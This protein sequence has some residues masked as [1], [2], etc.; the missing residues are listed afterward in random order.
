MRGFLIMLDFLTPRGYF[1]YQRPTEDNNNPNVTY[2]DERGN[3]IESTFRY[4]GPLKGRGQGEPGFFLQ[5][6]DPDNAVVGKTLAKFDL[7]AAIQEAVLNALLPDAENPLPEELRSSVNCAKLTALHNGKERDAGGKFIGLA[8]IQKAVD[9]QDMAKFMVSPE[10]RAPQA[11]LREVDKAYASSLDN[12]RDALSEEAQFH[13]AAALLQSE[14]ANDESKHIGQF[15]LLLDARGQIEKVVRIDLGAAYR[16]AWAKQLHHADSPLKASIFYNHH[17]VVKGEAL[18]LET[19]F[20]SDPLGKDYTSSQLR[21][22]GIRAK[23]L[24]LALERPALTEATII[25]RFTGLFEQIPGDAVQQ[26]R[27]AL[28]GFAAEFYKDAYDPNQAKAEDEDGFELLDDFKFNEH[29]KKLPKAY[30]AWKKIHKDLMD[31]QEAREKA[32]ADITQAGANQE[33]EQQARNEFNTAENMIQDLT[34]AKNDALIACENILRKICLPDSES[35]GP[36]VDDELNHHQEGSIAHGLAQ[37]VAEATL[38]KHQAIVNH[39]QL[40]ITRCVNGANVGP[41]ISN[42]LTT[43]ASTAPLTPEQIDSLTAKHTQLTARKKSPLVRKLIENRLTLNRCY[44]EDNTLKA[45]STAVIT[46]LGLQGEKRRELLKTAKQALKSIAHLTP[47]A[48]TALKNINNALRQRPGSEPHLYDLLSK[49][50]MFDIL[51]Q[52][53]LMAEAPQRKEEVKDKR[54]I[55]WQKEAPTYSAAQTLFQAYYKSFDL[56]GRNALAEMQDEEIEVRQ[57]F[58][59]SSYTSL[60]MSHYARQLPQRVPAVTAT[61]REILAIFFPDDK[62]MDDDAKNQHISTN[63]LDKLPL[64]HLHWVASRAGA[65]WCMEH[66]TKSALFNQQVKRLDFIKVHKGCHQLYAAIKKLPPHLRAYPDTELRRIID[67]LRNGA[68]NSKQLEAQLA[69]LIHAT[70]KAPAA[71][72]TQW[73][74][75]L[76]EGLEQTPRI[77]QAIEHIR[78]EDNATPLHALLKKTLITHVMDEYPEHGQTLWE[79]QQQSLTLARVTTDDERVQE[80]ATLG[81][82]YP[83]FR[84]LQEAD[85]SLIAQY[86]RLLQDENPPTVTQGARAIL[87]SLTREAALTTSPEQ[88]YFIASRAGGSNWYNNLPA[89]DNADEQARILTLKGLFVQG[90]LLASHENLSLLINKLRALPTI[91]D[92][93]A[94]HIDKLSTSLGLLLSLPNNADTEQSIQNLIRQVDKYRAFLD[95]AEKNPLSSADIEEMMQAF[96]LDEGEMTS[97]HALTPLQDKSLHPFLPNVDAQTDGSPAKQL[98]GIALI[99]HIHDLARAKTTPQAL[100]RQAKQLLQQVPAAFSDRA[101]PIIAQL[102]AEARRPDDHAKHPQAIIPASLIFD[103]QQE[104]QAEKTHDIA[105]GLEALS[106]YGREAGYLDEGDEQVDEEALAAAEEQR[107]IRKAE[108]R[109]LIDERREQSPDEKLL[110]LYERELDNDEHE[111][112]AECAQ[113]ALR[114]FLRDMAANRPASLQQFSVADFHFV[115]SRAGSRWIN[116]NRDTYP[117]LDTFLKRVIV[118][119]RPRTTREALPLL[120]HTPALHELFVTIK[121]LP[122]GAVRRHANALLNALADDSLVGEEERLQAEHVAQGLASFLKAYQKNPHFGMQELLSFKALFQLQPNAAI[123]PSEPEQKRLTGLPASPHDLFQREGLTPTQRLAKIFMNVLYQKERGV[124]I[125][126]RVAIEALNHDNSQFGQFARGFIATPAPQ[127]ARDIDNEKYPTYSRA[128]Q[129]ID[130]QREDD[131]NRT[132]FIRQEETLVGRLSTHKEQQLALLRN[133]FL[134]LDLAV[135]EMTLANASTG[136]VLQ[137]FDAITNRVGDTLQRQ[138]KQEIARCV[139]GLG[140]DNNGRHPTAGFPPKGLLIEGCEE[141]YLKPTVDAFNAKCA[142]SRQ[143]LE[144]KVNIMRQAKVQNKLTGTS[145]PRAAEESGA[146]ANFSLTGRAAQ[147]RQQLLTATTISVNKA[148]ITIHP[149]GR[150]TGLDQFSDTELL[151]WLRGKTRVFG[152]KVKQNFAE[153]LA[154]AGYRTFNL[155]MIRHADLK[156]Q[157]ACHHAAEEGLR[158]Y[159][160]GRPVSERV[161]LLQNQEAGN[162]P[163]PNFDRDNNEPVD[164]HP[165]PR[166]TLVH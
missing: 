15:M 24:S 162:A 55:P 70:E 111:D 33:A 114:A 86:Y 68:E 41:A 60:L 148:F 112:V 49:R 78:A 76:L 122:P 10:G 27:E 53:T 136:N 101:K 88:A 157:A 57:A 96:D 46:D 89:G 39:A 34:G 141:R 156:M 38:S 144:T 87:T 131:A 6:L 51:D 9:G 66:R 63:E 120:G 19:V 77:A 163:L 128:K 132:T 102:D 1:T 37:H 103:M 142:E 158:R 85:Q 152:F 92:T 145:V 45:A 79:L 7:E 116:D 166:P 121:G 42:L 126:P 123:F 80:L 105:A 124:P 54:K 107:D 5:Q 8:S 2:R 59:E 164:N 75:N 32:I 16:Y 3:E 23:F 139:S 138:C 12:A 14:F 58:V 35:T 153:V 50:V 21:H 137:R 47:E 4:V 20:G 64:E 31:A 84:D 127:R 100:C 135:E 119:M 118:I 22:P 117:L 18:G 71:A 48:K 146:S 98:M 161:S 36:F 91:G 94:D 115:A 133:E 30:K 93:F 62:R 74:L 165:R 67:G 160:K 99:Q 65:A 109:S 13:L 143:H 40:E 44:H 159:N 26:Q 69:G 151:S 52:A 43:P 155:N 82:K 140:H 25:Q 129:G 154:A 125:S 95:D 134:A 90:Q 149:G 83:N 106:A 110:H 11:F 130:N 28:V 113:A 61:A 29:Y 108:E 73:T 17:K 81:A 150:I 56:E 72:L 104:E 147:A 97:Q